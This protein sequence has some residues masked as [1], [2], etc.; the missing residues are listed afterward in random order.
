[1][2]NYRKFID[3]IEVLER[4]TNSVVLDI[5][6][7]YNRISDNYS[8]NK[9]R[10]ELKNFVNSVDPSKI[11]K[12]KNAQVTTFEKA[13][14]YYLNDEE[15]LISGYTTLNKFC[16]NKEFRPTNLKKLLQEKGYLITHYATEKSFLSN[17]LIVTIKHHYRKSGMIDKLDLIFLWKE[18]FLIDLIS[19][20][21]NTIDKYA[22]D[23]KYRTPR[24]KRENLNEIN[25]YAKPLYDSE[26]IGTE[27]FQLADYC[28]DYPY[29]ELVT[30]MINH[31]MSPKDFQSF[32]EL[33]MTGVA[34]KEKLITD[35]LL[36]DKFLSKKRMLLRYLKNY[37]KHYC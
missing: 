20:N 30:R 35:P 16:K 3:F 14:I 13:L 36:L 18:S 10:F 23:Y 6:D 26:F 1:M 33:L 2:I 17:N 12:I 37:Q 25:K 7:F 4:R 34:Y 22:S 31:D 8:V 24:T 19:R 15:K 21:K 28:G 11:L 27:N 5:P 32:H 29:M 9:L